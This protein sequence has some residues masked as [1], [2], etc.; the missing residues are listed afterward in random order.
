MFT[1][2]WVFLLLLFWRRSGYSDSKVFMPLSAHGLTSLLQ[3]YRLHSYMLNTHHFLCVAKRH[4]LVTLLLLCGDILLN[5]GP[6][7]FGAVSAGTN[8]F[9][10]S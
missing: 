3:P 5:P 1:I 6:I 9:W 4:G 7:S 10:S 8:L 2:R